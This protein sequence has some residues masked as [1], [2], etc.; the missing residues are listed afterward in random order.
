VIDPQQQAIHTSM[1]KID[2]LLSKPAVL[3][4]K[5]ILGYMGDKVP[6]PI[7]LR[8]VACAHIA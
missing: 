4:F 6:C 5:N 2:V 3:C 1:T 7:A 8:C